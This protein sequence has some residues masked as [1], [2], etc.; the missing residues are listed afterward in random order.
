ML[1]LT[2]MSS[3]TEYIGA[4]RYTELEEEWGKLFILDSIRFAPLFLQSV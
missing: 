3:D 2:E 1:D 4:R